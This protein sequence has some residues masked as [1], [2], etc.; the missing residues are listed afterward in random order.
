M[1][2]AGERYTVAVDFDGVIHAYTTPWVNAATI[3]DAPVDGA[4]VWLHRTLQK[5]DVA[6]TSTR[7]HQP[8]GVMAMRRWL[9]KHSG[10][11]WNESPGYRGLEDIT[12]PK[13]KPAALIYLDDR[14]VR[15]TGANWPSPQDIHNARPWNK[16]VKRG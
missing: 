10:N 4:I 5:F 15:F 6:I 1:K 3:P 8:F 16:G 9:R 2:P 13:K 11:L 7:N 12:F 14:A